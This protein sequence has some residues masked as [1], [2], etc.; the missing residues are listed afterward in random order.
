[1]ISLKVPAEQQTGAPLQPV[2][3]LM[4]TDTINQLILLPVIT[5]QNCLSEL[6]QNLLKYLTLPS[7]RLLF[8]LKLFL[9][10]GITHIA[11]DM[12]D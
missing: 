7:L 8:Q 6:S 4:V 10:V 1:M 3:M 12:K 9:C 2:V 11:V 5:N